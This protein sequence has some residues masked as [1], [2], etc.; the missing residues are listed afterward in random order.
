VR[1]PRPVPDWIELVPERDE[2]FRRADFVSLHV[3]ATTETFRIVGRREL[4]LMK[5]AAY[6]LNTAR[7]DVVD[8]KALIDALR[9]GDIAGAAVDTFEQ[10]PPDPANPLFAMGN[11]IVTPHSAALTV[12]AMD[13][14]AIQAGEEIKRVLNGGRP[15]WPVNEP[16]ARR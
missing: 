6:L 8:E 5:R 16:K 4:G 15:R 2:I 14:M 3:P 11:V 12:E 1:T 9:N 7:G 10:E 13:R